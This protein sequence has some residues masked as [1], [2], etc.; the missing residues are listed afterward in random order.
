MR[1]QP[2][3]PDAQKT[4]Q[5]LVWLLACFREVLE[6]IGEPDL[7]ASLAPNGAARPVA[8]T[9]RLFAQ[10]CSIVFQLLN[11]VEE[12]TAV[13]ARASATPER[14]PRG[15]AGPLGTN[16]PPPA[17]GGRHGGRH[18]GGAAARPRRAG[19][20][21]APDGG[22]A[23]H[24]PR[25]PP[26]AVPA[27]ARSRADRIWTPQEQHR[28]REQIKALIERLWR[29]GEIFLEKSRRRLRAAQRGTTLRACSRTCCRS[30]MRG[31]A[32]PGWTRACRRRRSME[33]DRLPRVSFGTWVGGD[34]DGHPLVT[35]D[36][37]PRR[38]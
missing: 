9:P 26:R 34:R 18:R 24:G 30:S 15:R 10:L 37:S 3:S 17:A 31:C 23:R 5:D 13:Q 25:A 33:P 29:T 1:T 12:N 16:A 22:Q 7:A 38:R 21:R 19:A 11:M 14:G 32:R 2:V 27:A 8:A 20:H 35:A 6:E 28:I 36:R 4:E